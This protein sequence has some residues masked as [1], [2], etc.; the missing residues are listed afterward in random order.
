MY[1]QIFKSVIAHP[2]DSLPLKL[3]K[4]M[5]PMDALGDQVVNYQEIGQWMGVTK[6]TFG[7]FETAMSLIKKYSNDKIDLTDSEAKKVG[8]VYRIKLS[9]QEAFA[10]ALTFPERANFNDQERLAWASLLKD[11]QIDL[12]FW[13]RNVENV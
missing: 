5:V 2:A 7:Y 10:Q 8:D 6:D 4:S 3:A 13:T 1:S 9:G 11:S 12:Y